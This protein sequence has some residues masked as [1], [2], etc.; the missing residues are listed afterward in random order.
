[1]RPSTVEQTRELR[2]MGLINIVQYGKQRFF[3][4][5]S[6][7][8]TYIEP[9]LALYPPESTNISFLP[10]RQHNLNGKVTEEKPAELPDWLVE[11]AKDA[12]RELCANSE[13]CQP[14]GNLFA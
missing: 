11:P 12:I 5:E 7:P 2:R 14:K 4:P 3:L 13:I 10:E 6:S 8:Q 9:I 1:V